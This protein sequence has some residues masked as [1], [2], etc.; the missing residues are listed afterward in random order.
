[1]TLRHRLAPL[2]L[3][4]LV[5]PGIVHAHGRKIRARAVVPV[6]AAPVVAPVIA[7]PVVASPL[8]GSRV[9]T[10][11]VIVGSNR[12]PS[13]AT[14][15]LHY[16]DDD[17]V[18]GARTLDLLGATNL[19][20]V[21]PDQETREL[22]PHMSPHESPTRAAVALAVKRAFALLAE[23]H[24]QGRRTRFYFFFAGHG[25]VAAGRPFLQLE[26]GR[27]FRDD[28]AALLHDSPADEHHLVIDACHASLFVADR[29]AGGA[30]A[31]VSPGFSRTSG[32]SWPTHTGLFTARSVGDKTHEWTEFQAGIFSHEIRSGLLGAADADRNGRVTYRELGAFIRRANE[33]IVNRKYRP[34]V[35]TQPPG[36]DPEATFA[37]LPDGPMVLELD[38]NPG[39]IFVDSENGVR[40]ADLHP[41]PGLRLALRLPTDLG[42]LYLQEVGSEREVRLVPHNGR[43][44]LSQLTPTPARARARGA[45][46]EA[47]RHLF[48]HPFDAAAVR[49]FE[50][51]LADLTDTAST[52]EPGRPLLPW[53]MTSTGVAANVAA[54]GMG[55]WGY[56]RAAAAKNQSG[57]ERATLA[58]D[59]DRSNRAAMVVGAIGVA[60]AAG[61]L[62]WL[63]LSRDAGSAEGEGR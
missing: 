41:A 59:L 42:P 31:A 60:L 62:S 36:G 20:L 7:A 43:L 40:L 8:D 39:R 55:L 45:A 25:D 58:R 56:Q 34:E 47:F 15:D 3:L 19:L 4:A 24:T 1:M 46:H 26:D 53:I 28:L 63:W 13:P 10:A 35:V 27:L 9:V 6:I 18:Q 2:G 52:D 38:T 32:P 30:R 37:E 33:A 48:N 5:L 57:E 17:A 11:A 29:G 61:G 44:L 22:F 12:S 21:A 14:P 50:P 51:A 16:A 23:A 49:G 54:I